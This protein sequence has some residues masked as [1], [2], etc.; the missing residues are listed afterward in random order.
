MAKKKDPPKAK[1][2]PIKRP[3]YFEE[4]SEKFENI[5]LSRGW[6]MV[7]VKR[8]FVDE[9]YLPWIVMNAGGRFSFHPEFDRDHF[10]P[11]ARYFYFERAADADKFNNQFNG[12]IWI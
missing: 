6:R 7:E 12:K 9:E 8:K 3:K 1:S 5:F 11:K 10:D 4:H 2:T